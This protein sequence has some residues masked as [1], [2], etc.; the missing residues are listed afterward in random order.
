[1]NPPQSKQAERA[2]LGACIIDGEAARNVVDRVAEDDFADRECRVIYSAVRELVRRGA[3]ID[4]VT[5]SDE[6]GDRVEEVGGNTGICDLIDSTPSSVNYE[7]VLEASQGGP[8]ALRR[9][10][11][12][13]SA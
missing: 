3:A 9:R 4:V 10:C 5:L 6:L 8:G 1:M 13:L 12:R 11:L 7:P 2:L